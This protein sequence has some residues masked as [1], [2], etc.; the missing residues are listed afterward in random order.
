MRKYFHRLSL[1]DISVP[2]VYF[3]FSDIIYAQ[4]LTYAYE[5]LI[6]LYFKMNILNKFYSTALEFRPTPR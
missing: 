2:N 5:N 6:L 1:K 3:Y 4:S